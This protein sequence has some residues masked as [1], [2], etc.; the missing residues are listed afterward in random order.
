[1]NW[2]DLFNSACTVLQVT[3]ISLLYSSL[4]TSPARS[5]EKVFLDYG[6]IGRSVPTTSLEAF[7]QNGT[8]DAELAPYLSD[9]SLEEQQSLQRLLGTPLTS[10]SPEMAETVGNPFVLSQWL[11]SPIGEILLGTAGQLVQTESRQ[12]SPQAVRAAMILAAADMEGLSLLNVI[13]FYPTEGIRLNLPQ[14]LAFSGAIEAN[15]ETTEQLVEVTRQQS[16]AAANNEPAL[17]YAALPMLADEPQFEVDVRSLI[18]NDPERDRT[19]PVD[20]YLPEDLSTLPGPLPVMIFSHGYADT[21]SHPETVAAARSLAANGFVVAVPEHIG[22]NQTYQENLEKGLV[23]ESFDVMEFIHRPQDIRFLLDTLTQKNNSE[24]Q[25]RLKLDR[26]GIV[27]H[28]FGGYT[29]LALA[30]ATVDVDLLKEQCAV[31]ADFTPANVNIALLLQCRLLELETSPQLMQQLTD[32]TL[33]DDRVGF[34]FAMSPLSNLFGEE[35]VSH[36][37]VPVAI[38]GGG[39]DIATPVM[40]EQLTMFQGLE[41]PQK[42]FYLGDNLSHTTELTRA[43]LQL[44]HPRSDVADQFRD[45]EQW[46]FNL[47]VTLVI[48]HGKTS[49]LADETYQPYLSAAYVESNS[50]AP[51]RVHLLRSLTAISEF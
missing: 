30:G 19:Y 48:A 45:S 29:A 13:R 44:V 38:L 14:I 22:S 42:Y 41:T 28:S 3:A 17:N 21:R 7:A 4:F 46:L 33:A 1:M 26:V 25:G 49:L 5:A 32:G 50:V 10:L 27:G 31:D 23:D 51:T 16:E 15:I 37:Q 9:V 20:L 43:I 40:Q 36:I 24:F 34:V 6:F 8:L 47:V 39:Y 12:S 35:G 11:Y 18:L 2:K